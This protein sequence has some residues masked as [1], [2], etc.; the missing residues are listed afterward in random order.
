MSKY[1]AG[2]FILMMLAS[3]LPARAED[4]GS[5]AEAKAMASRAAEYLQKAGPD[6]AFPEFEKAASFHDRDL[7]VMVYDDNG[8]CVSH[9]ANPALIGRD[10]ID[11]KDTEGKPLIQ[12]F[13][14]VKNSGWVD[15]K[16]P[17]PVTKKIEPKATYL[18]RVGT[19][20]VGV[21]AYKP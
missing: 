6:K 3:V 17:N 10:L 15:Y 21:G 14:A 1:I 2:L 13:V 11:L 4:R 8:K 16:W 7:Y 19:Y 12:E 20:L 5:P 18:V 9:G